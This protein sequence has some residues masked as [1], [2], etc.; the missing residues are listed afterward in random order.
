[1]RQATA[2]DTNLH[3]TLKNYSYDYLYEMMSFYQHYNNPSKRV[4]KTP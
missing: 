1:M 3:L 2:K 4:T